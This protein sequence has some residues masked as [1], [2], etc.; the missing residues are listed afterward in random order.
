MKN[1]EYEN[2]RS[3]VEQSWDRCI[4]WGL[5]HDFEPTP[6]APGAAQVEELERQ[7]HELLAST[8]AE[9]LPYYRNVLSSSRCLILLANRH[10]TVLKSW[11][12]ERITGAQ[13]KPW[14]QQGS[15]WQ[16]ERCGTNAIGTAIAANKAVQIQRNEHFLKLNRSMIGSAAP[17]FDAHKQLVGVLSV[18]SDAYLPQA[19][20]L[21]VVRLLAQ[22]VD[23]RLLKR[24]F[25][26][27]HFL[28]TLST[29]ADNFDSPWSGILICDDLGRVVA[30]N[31]RADQLLSKTTVGVRLDDLFTTHRN[32][33]LGHPPQSALQLSTKN[34]VRLSAKVQRPTVVQVKSPSEDDLVARQTKATQT[35]SADFSTLEYGDATVRRCAEQSLKVLERGVPVLITG[36]TGV[37]K[38]VLV[39]ALHQATQRREQALVAVNC[40]AIPPELVESELFG[41]EAGAFTGARAQ[42]SLGFIRKAHK[43]ILFL[44]EIGE[45]PLSAQ[46]RLLRVLQERVVTPVGATDS[47]AVDILLITATNRAPALHVE[48]GQLRADL[49]YRINGL[50]VELPALRDRTDKQKLVQHIYS[51]YRDP[52]QSEALSPRILAALTNHPWPGNIRQLVNVVR[53]AVAIAD[54]EDLQIWHLPADFL[55]Q[56]DSTATGNLSDAVTSAT[57]ESGSEATFGEL[58]KAAPEPFGHTLQVYQ[59]CMGNISSAARELSI[60]RNTL[61]KRLRELGVR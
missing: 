29:T 19:H 20:T 9:V 33:I 35:N 23:N 42:G 17:I 43:G 2:E 8:E 10:A 54:G 4:A 58:K 5:D 30:S 28:L 18:F 16:E 14:F 41:Y 34:R 56:L 6:P 27:D 13:L 48:S 52:V 55:A 24:Q 31:Q 45:M 50:C 47:I 26:R 53:V 21:G 39:K 3:L 51:Q 46:S 25:E 12:D 49:Y 57:G 36:E 59:K 15:N 37:G 38:E 44:D 60:S 61:Y 7:Y 40:A 22:S 32:H 1:T 11:G